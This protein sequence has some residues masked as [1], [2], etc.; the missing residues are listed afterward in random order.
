MIDFAHRAFIPEVEASGRVKGFRMRLIIIALVAL[1]SMASF[2]ASA[3]FYGGGP[4]YYQEEDEDYAPRR[5]RPRDFYEREYSQPRYRANP[6]DFDERDY[7]P[8]RYRE[9]Y[10][11][12]RYGSRQ[13]LGQVCVTARGN[14]PAPAGPLNS[15]C[16]CMIPGFGPKRGAIG[17]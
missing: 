6:D 9:T 2:P 7:S 4:R 10:E 1:V 3:Q 13:R 16:G 11:R 14:C 12:P 5:H 17:F 15:P 8:R